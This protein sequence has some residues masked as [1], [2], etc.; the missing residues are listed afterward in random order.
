MMRIQRLSFPL[1]FF[2]FLTTLGA[3][4]QLRRP[5]TW[6]SSLSE[7]PV[8][9]GEEVDLIF[10]AKIK[11]DWY[12]YSSDFDPD[13]GPVVTEFTF[14]PDE[15]YELVGGLRPIKPKEKYDDLFGGDYT[16]FKGKGEFRQR[17]KIL[18][19]EPTI[20]AAVRGQTCSEKNGECILIEEEFS[21]DVATTG[22]EAAPQVE[23]Q[24]TEPVTRPE[25]SDNQLNT[26][27][28]VNDTMPE[29]EETEK[30]PDTTSQT[31]Q[32]LKQ[33]ETTTSLI[34][35]EG[36][37][38]EEK[39]DNESLWGFMLIAFLSG[40]AAL[41]TPCVF[42]MIPMTVSFFTG[43]GKKRS[44]GIGRALFYGASIIGIYTGIGLVFSSIFGA[45]AANILSTHWL[46]NVIF[47]AVFLI[48][49]ISFFGAFEIVLPSGFVNSVDKQADKGGL[50]GIFFMALTLAVVSFSCTGPIAGS[51]LFQSATGE[52]MKPALGMFAFSLAF[53]LPFTLFA[54]F[55]S[56]LDTLPKSGG[57]L[58][59]VKVVLGFVELA[60]AF[61]FLSVADQVY[62]WGLLD[63][64]IYIA[65][66]T[67]ISIAMGLYLLGVYRL[68]NDSVEDK[69]GVNR[70]LLAI[71]SFIFAIYL[72]PGMF[73]APLQA[74]SG[75]LPPQSTHHFDLRQIIR[76]EVGQAASSSGGV[77]TTAALTAKPKYSDFLHLPHGLDGY[78]ELEQAME[79]AKLQNKP[80]FIDFTGHGC[81]NCRE[82][83]ANVWSAPPVLKRLR[84]DFIV[85]AL[86]VDD[87]TPLP[88]EEWITSSF[89]GKVK[90]TI[91]KRNADIQITYFNKNAQPY[92]VLLS[93]DGKVLV[94]PMGYNLDVGEFVDFLDRGLDA[95]RELR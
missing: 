48:F 29:E 91:G 52:F 93:P 8:K 22:K 13:L 41:L 76:E 67:G 59:T 46:P 56:W 54:L 68:P 25:E 71:G 27:D 63:R 37:L 35:V 12:L 42:P 5:V 14:T 33:D 87:R 4:A 1:I 26:K 51:I 28:S 72:I 47:F 9:V 58:N 24:Q 55:P 23:E 83:E 73:G 3:Q 80:L 77:K 6:A 90:K 11:R 79:V 20:E 36:M 16:Y 19:P 39:N 94:P 89:D 88:E 15:S 40:L 7:M 34:R 70:L 92:Y 64:P 10:T 57:W 43:K 65:I 85:T 60:L 69:I 74:L 30:T 66:W 82:M 50:V 95:Y 84:E 21:I 32:T 49:A 17:V 44:K 2:L 38:D 53:A 62:H 86:Y 45:D 78:F 31:E 81:V 18:K 61:K 75:Y